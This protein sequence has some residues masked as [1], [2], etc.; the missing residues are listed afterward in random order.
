MHLSLHQIL[1]IAALVFAALATAAV[2][3][4]PRWQWLP[5]SILFLILA[6]V[7]I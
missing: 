3:S 6:F 2:P 4:P 5:A 1:L 7:F